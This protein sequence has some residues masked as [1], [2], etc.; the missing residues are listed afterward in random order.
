M[1]NN[2][3]RVTMALDML[4]AGLAP[5]VE[6]S[7]KNA[8]GDEW[9]RQARTSFRDDR[10]R[11]GDETEIHWDGHSLLTVMWDQW[12][13]AFRNVLG[14]KE[15]SL[16]S[17]LREFRNQWAHQLDFDYD[18]TYRVLDSI[19]RLLRAAAA[20]L[21]KRVR[22][23]KQELMR[24]QFTREAKAAYRRSQLR[25]RTWQDL[26]I[27]LVCCAALVTVTLQFFGLGAWVVM[28]FIFFVFGYL[29]Y[30]RLQA[31]PPLIFG[32][33]ECGACRR[34]IYGAECPYCEKALG[35]EASTFTSAAEWF[36]EMPDPPAEAVSEPP[37]RRKP[38]AAKPVG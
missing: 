35:I 20:P 17:E 25:K 38:K 33:H 12:N 9:Y 37:P 24:A 14:H 19:E 4:V 3:E 8:Y 34:I 7:L 11:N 32:P 15:R 30:Q 2:R 31:H 6:R 5:F 16:V 13:R 29:S 26:A 21:A 27:Y 10:G 23:E 1:R 22:R 28:G 36:P 18:D